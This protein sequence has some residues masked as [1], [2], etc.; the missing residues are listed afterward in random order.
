MTIQSWIEHLPKLTT[1]Y[2][3]KDIWNI[4]ELGLF[5]QALLAFSEK[6][7]V[8]KST[9]CKGSKKSKQ[10]FTTA[11][12][13]APDCSKVPEPVVIWKSKLPRCFNNIHNKARPSMVHYLSNKKV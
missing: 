13:V 12:F 11:F 6:G 5:F 2:E 10:R 3:L 7:L 4:D 9:S 1:G 8:Q